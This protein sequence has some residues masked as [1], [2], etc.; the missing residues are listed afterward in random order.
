VLTNDDLEDVGEKNGSS[1][2]TGSGGSS[3]DRD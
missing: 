1:I 3:S 2:G